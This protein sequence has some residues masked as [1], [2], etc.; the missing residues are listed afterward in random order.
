MLAPSSYWERPL[1]AHS[2]HQ[3]IHPLYIVYCTMLHCA[4]ILHCTKL[5]MYYITP[6][7][8]LSPPTHSSTIHVVRNTACSHFAS[9][10]KLYQISIT[11]VQSACPK[12]ACIATQHSHQPF[13]ILTLCTKH[14]FTPESPKCQ[15]AIIITQ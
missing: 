6:I 10:N 3:T 13:T 9:T 2:A 14:H 5:C 8:P 1:S 7:L 4:F 15:Q 12:Q 11:K